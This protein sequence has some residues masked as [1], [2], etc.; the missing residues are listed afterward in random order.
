M[1]VPALHNITA[2]HLY[3]DTHIIDATDDAATELRRLGEEG[4]VSLSV[5]DAMDTEL[6]DAPPEKWAAL[7][8]LSAQ[9]PESYGPAIVGHSRLDSSVVASE[10]DKERFDRVFAILFPGTAG[11]AAVRDNHVR[12]AMHV[13][14]A[15]RYGGNAFI[16]RE[17][18]LRNKNAVIA[19]QFGGFHI[20]SPE[21]ALAEA[22]A[23]IRGVRELRRREPS[24]ETLPAWPDDATLAR[25]TNGP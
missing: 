25:W 11:P 12:D 16:T 6:A 13:S 3:V 21:D 20:W 1:P 4:W 17:K 19:E 8:G 9:Y 14:T 5:T 15:V 22:A 23:R 7:T 18:K 24:R 2:L 10:E